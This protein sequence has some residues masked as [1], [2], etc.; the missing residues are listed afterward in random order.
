MQPKMRRSVNDLVEWQLTKW[1]AQKNVKEKEEAVVKPAPCITVSREAGSGGSEIAR[2]LAKELDMD[3]IG[4]QII[5]QIAE[6]T[7]MSEKVIASLDEKEVRLI[8]T[9]MDSFFKA[10]HIWPNEYLRHLTHV[11]GTIG[12]QGNAIIVGHGAQFI[13]PEAETFRLRVIAPR[14]VRVKNVM[15]DSNYNQERAE[16]YVD[17]AEANRSAYIRQ[18]FHVDWTTPGLYDLILNT[19]N[20]GIEGA[21]A[22]VKAAFLVWRAL[23]RE[24]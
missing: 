2:Q 11:I 12:Q 1:H 14:E 19:G 8:D 10:R 6:R 17:T 21:V 9:M 16:S 7:D 5:R 20:M 15:R 18:H 23:P 22:A 3:I 24:R 13:L 4:S